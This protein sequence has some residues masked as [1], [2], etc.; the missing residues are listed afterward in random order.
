MSFLCS[1]LA[2]LLLSQT[3]H[4]S[5]A[6]A[7]P[8][9]SPLPPWSSGFST[10]GG[11]REKWPPLV[12]SHTV[13][14]LGAYSHALLLLLQDKLWDWGR[15]FLTLGC[16][17]L[18]D[19]AIQNLLSKRK[20]CWNMP[21]FVVMLLKEKHSHKFLS[22]LVQG[23]EVPQGDKVTTVRRVGGC[24]G[25]PRWGRGRGTFCYTWDSANKISGLRK[26]REW[27]LNAPW[28]HFF[29]ACPPP[30]QIFILG[31]GE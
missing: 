10:L 25:R 15:N 19:G 26:G 4:L 12:A 14:E 24:L 9:P 27:V 17:T 11:A 13:G 29:F 23:D 31:L 5:P 16:N 22:R 7:N 28:C 8:P 30:L 21:I 3:P 20:S 1:K 6:N 18:G 2:S